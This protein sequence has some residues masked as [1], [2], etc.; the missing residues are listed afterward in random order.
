MQFEINEKKYQGTNL[1]FQSSKL[2]LPQ[3]VLKKTSQMTPIE[4]ILV[5]HISILAG[6][7]KLRF[8]GKICLVVPYMQRSYSLELRDSEMSNRAL[9]FYFWGARSQDPI[10]GSV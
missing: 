10:G 4:S 5:H 1:C 7:Q 9:F 6:L 3:F 2:N 8:S